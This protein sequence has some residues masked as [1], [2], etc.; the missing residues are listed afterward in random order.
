MLIVCVK[1][2]IAQQYYL[3]TNRAM[4]IMVLKEA[5][6][7]NYEGGLSID[8]LLDVCYIDM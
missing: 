4:R 1:V 5:I 7:F 6:L 3:D 2:E 8:K